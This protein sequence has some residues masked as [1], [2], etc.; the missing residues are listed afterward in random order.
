MF[1]KVSDLSPQI[2]TTKLIEEVTVSIR[3]TIGTMQASICSYKSLD[4]SFKTQ[5][6]CLGHCLL[7]LYQ[8]IWHCQSYKFSFLN[9]EFH[10]HDQSF[11]N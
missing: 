9:S 1:I 5:K 4:V 2:S 6:S 11:Y 7:Y 3:K 10:K 8:N